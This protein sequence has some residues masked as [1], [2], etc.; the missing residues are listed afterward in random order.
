ELISK[1]VDKEANRFIQQWP[2]EKIAIENGR[3]GP[4]IRFGKQMVKLGKNPATNE[5]Y[6]AE[7]LKDLGLDE[8]KKLITDQ[9]PE[10]FTAK[11][12]K[13]ATKTPAKKTAAKTGVKK[14]AAKKP[15][16]AK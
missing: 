10:A 12:K 3:W 5:K 7:E 4:F 11:T 8:V 2:E 16:K 6:S 15:A 14:T 13:A 9:I 1:K